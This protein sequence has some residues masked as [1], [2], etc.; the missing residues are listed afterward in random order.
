MI[1]FLSSSP[2]GSYLED[3]VQKPCRLSEENDFLARLTAVWPAS[4]HCLLI[5]AEPDQTDEN[6]KMRS[7]FLTAFSLSDLPVARLELCDNRN[8]SCLPALLAESDV[9]LLSGGHTLTQNRFFK[10]IHLKQHIKDF[11]GVLIGMSGGSMNCAE[12][13]YAQPE[14]EGETLDAAYERF[15][16]GLGLTQMTILPHFQLLKSQTLDGKRLIED[17]AVPDSLGRSFYALPD[18]SYVQIKNGKSELVG[19]GY[20]ICNGFIHGL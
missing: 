5:C 13:V 4:A 15:P 11:D 16:T 18:G 17:V 8:A 14:W 19:E 3:G 9:V 1:A 10:Q 7:N 12:V 6:D 2:G 20:L